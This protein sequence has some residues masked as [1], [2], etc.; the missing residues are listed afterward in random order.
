MMLCNKYRLSF[1][2]YSILLMVSLG[3]YAELTFANENNAPALVI[4]LDASNSMW[5]QVNGKTKIE[6]A[7][8]ELTK[9]LAKPELS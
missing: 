9:L 2:L 3:A 8:T 6:I 7:R 1:R 4:V 5:G